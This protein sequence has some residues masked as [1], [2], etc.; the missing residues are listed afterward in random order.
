MLSKIWNQK[1][2]VDYK[3]LKF[4]YIGPTEGVS[5]YG[6]MNSKELFNS[7]KS[8]RIKF[9]DPV[10]KQNEFLNKQ[11]NIKIVKKNHQAKRSN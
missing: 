9:R 4:G 8:S 6:Y 2:S 5:F 10:N 3:D 11:N 1:N 7:I